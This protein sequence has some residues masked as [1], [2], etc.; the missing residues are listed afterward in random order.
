MIGFKAKKWLSQL[1]PLLAV[2]M[3]LL[4][5][6][7]TPAA[8]AW[9]NLSP[10]L[11]YLELT[12]H[13]LSPWSH[14]HAFRI[15]LQSN[16]IESLL[17]S[18]LAKKYASAKEYAEHSKA[19]ITINGGFFDQ[20]YTPLG[21]RINNKTQKSPFKSISWW[22]VFYVKNGVAHL[23]SVRQFSLDKHIEFAVQSGP[24]LIV[25]GKIPA[26]KAGRAQRSA[27]GINK[28][29]QIIIVITDNAPI[30]T[31]ELAHLMKAPPLNCVNALNLD[32]GGSTQL[33]ADV[34]SFQLDVLGFSNVSDAVV[35]KS[36]S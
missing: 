17:A 8:T 9:H 1:K 12:K 34:N 26:L 29:G 6:N 28:N 21:L 11:D 10:G 24:R 3:V 25:N 23:S 16:A 13:Q 15:D 36:R 33:H 19:L 14:I 18:D 22:G 7:N 35:I 31:S 5:L 2:L 27:L 20:N 4:L 30:T 32:G